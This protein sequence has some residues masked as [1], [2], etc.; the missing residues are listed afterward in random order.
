MAKFESEYSSFP[1]KLITL[2]K[3]KDVD[4]TVASLINQ[5]NTLRAQGA[6]NQALV[7]IQNNIN[8][9]KQYIFDAT[10]IQTLTEEIYNTQLFALQTQQSIY[11]DTMPIAKQNDVWIGVT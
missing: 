11:F 6:Y 10:T 1:N 5:I 3:Y 7:F 2:R 4:D 8:T 9:L